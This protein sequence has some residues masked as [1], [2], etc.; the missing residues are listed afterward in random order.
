MY[1]SGLL[2]VLVVGASLLSP[3]DACVT[4]DSISPVFQFGYNAEI[5]NLAVRP[6]GNILF[7]EPSP[8]AN[9]WEINPLAVNGSAQLRAQFPNV[10]TALGIS[11]IGDDVFA[12]TTGDVGASFAG[13]L[14]TFAVHI[15]KYTGVNTAQITKTISIPQ[16]KLVNKITPLDPASDVI[17][18][19]DPES[20]HILAV[21]IT[22]GAIRTVLQD[23]ETMNATSSFPI[24]VNGLQT[25]DSTLYYINSAKALLCR[26]NINPDGTAAGPYEI[27]ANISSSLLLPDDFAILPS[28]EAFIA[29]SNEILY[30]QPDGNFSVIAGGE[31]ELQ[32]AGATSA[33]FGI[34]NQKHTLYVSTSGHDSKPGNSTDIT[35]GKI[36]RI[37]I[38]GLRIFTE[39]ES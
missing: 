25:I 21:N 28:G 11:S 32:L 22:S 15:L 4:A 7:T 16:G 2:S 12:I 30:V 34:G 36:V 31:Q 33:I 8:A 35:P 6:N 5:E 29:G 23:A 39:F 17:L 26:V 24:G 3:S 13:E 19:S 38:S 37:N 27:V 20:Y 10:T 14:G 9:V 1:S 18:V